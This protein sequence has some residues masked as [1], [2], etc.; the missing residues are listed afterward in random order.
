MDKFVQFE[1]PSP[2]VEKKGFFARYSLMLLVEYENNKNYEFF[3]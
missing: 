2:A 3:N 1:P